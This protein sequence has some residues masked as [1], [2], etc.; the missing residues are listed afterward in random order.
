MRS[1]FNRTWLFDL[2]NT[3]HNASAHIFPADSPSR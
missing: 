3:L 1:R 2:D